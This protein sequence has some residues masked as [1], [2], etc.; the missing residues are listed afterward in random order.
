MSEPEATDATPGPVAVR[1]IEMTPAAAAALQA[2]GESLGLDVVR[3]DLAGCVDKAGFLARTAEALA[4]PTWFGGNWDAF[5][6]C[7]ADLGW[8][9]GAGHVLVFEHA[10]DMRR[11]APEAL[12]TAVAV[13]GDAAAARDRRGLP[14]RV[15]LAA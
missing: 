8:R 7:L 15:F 1:V 9:P 2:L 3:I 4:F 6:D 14:F 11:L 12:D 13:L 5:F 10:E